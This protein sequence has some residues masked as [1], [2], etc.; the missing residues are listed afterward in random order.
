MNIH[1]VFKKL[2]GYW[3]GLPLVIQAFAMALVCA[4]SALTVIGLLYHFFNLDPLLL[5]ICVP[6]IA[7]ILYSYGFYRRIVIRLLAFERYAV[8]LSKETTVPRLSG[9]GDE[10]DHLQRL[11]EWM[12]RRVLEREN[13]LELLNKVLR[14]A[15]RLGGVGTWEYDCSTKEMWW[16][17]GLYKLLGLDRKDNKPELEELI[18]RVHKDERATVHAAIAGLQKRCQPFDIVHRIHREEGDV[19]VRHRGTIV[20]V[21]SK[22]K[23]LG[24]LVD[25]TNEIATT[26][27][28]ALIKNTVDFSTDVIFICDPN[29]KILFVN[30]KFEEVYG[31][32]KEESIGKQPNILKSGLVPEDVYREMWTTILNKRSW[33]GTVIN[34]RSDGSFVKMRSRISPVLS[35]RGGLMGFFAIQ[36]VLEDVRGG[37]QARAA[38]MPRDAFVAKIEEILL[39]VGDSKRGC[40][41]LTAP[42]F[43]DIFAHTV[44]R[45]DIARY[46]TR[47]GT[48]IAKVCNELETEI[49]VD[50]V[51][52]GTLGEA[53]FGCFVVGGDNKTGLMV[54]QAIKDTVEDTDVYAHHRTT[55]SVGYC[56]FPEHGRTASMLLHAADIALYQAKMKGGNTVYEFTASDKFTDRSFSRLE[57]KARIDRALASGR[58]IP[59][60]QP[61]LNL[62]KM[63][64]EYFEALARLIDEDGIVHTPASFLRTAV[65]FGLIREIDRTI[66]LKTMKTA[67]EM[68]EKGKRFSFAVN[69]AAKELED[70]QWITFIMDARQEIKIP[71]D[72][73]IF[74]L[75]ETEAIGDL[76]RAESFLKELKHLGAKIALDDFGSGYSSFLYLKTLPVDLLKIDGAFIRKL[77]SDPID[78]LVV[79]SI[80]AISKDMGLLTIGEFVENKQTLEALRRLGVDYAQGYYVGKPAPE[81]ILNIEHLTKDNEPLY[82]RGDRIIT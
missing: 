22:K 30:S 29:G 81:P 12:A 23:A 68:L 4:F 55:A 62:R 65:Q 18:E 35:D 61:I 7:V 17:D 58:I 72:M 44:G 26:R 54:A 8:L 16:S 77:P 70:D 45:G 53:E 20:E 37:P 75:T 36:Q 38:I 13:G 40:L 82:S 10:I 5:A 24:G 19:F 42:D 33:M 3:F 48:R 46:L 15:E 60:F 1:R 52:V 50:E 49:S 9:S 27:E 2:L 73:F 78:Q 6:V 47:L 25:I 28:L 31:Y 39:A 71:L 80:T 56:F 34:K 21:A 51:V 76:H 66:V 41:I 63:T 59:Y 43:L 11:F 79:Q 64:V 32:T 14:E 67:R 74:E 69:L 57:E